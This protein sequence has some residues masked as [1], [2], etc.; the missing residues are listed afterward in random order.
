M[1]RYCAIEANAVEF[2]RNMKRL[3]LQMKR[4][5][6]SFLNPSKGELVKP[7]RKQRRKEK[8]KSHDSTV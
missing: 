2:V 6:R 7:N 5:R 8:V 3:T 1:C 4:L